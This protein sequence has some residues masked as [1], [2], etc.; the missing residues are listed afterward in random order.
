MSYLRNLAKIVRGILDELADQNAYRRFLD[1]HGRTHSPEAWRQ[2]QDEH[3][4]AKSRRGRC[5]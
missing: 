2:F 5:C 3:W 1:A 4:Q